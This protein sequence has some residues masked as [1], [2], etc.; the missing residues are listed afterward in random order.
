MSDDL[1]VIFYIKFCKMNNWNFE[2]INYDHLGSG[3]KYW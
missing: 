2:K 1:N 3:V